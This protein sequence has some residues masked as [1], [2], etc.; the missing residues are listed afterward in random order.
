MSHPAQAEQ[1]IDYLN[2]EESKRNFKNVDGVVSMGYNPM[3]FEIDTWGSPSQDDSSVGRDPG[4][5]ELATISRASQLAGLDTVKVGRNHFHASKVI[6]HSLP[7]KGNRKIFSTLHLTNLCS[8]GL[9]THWL[10]L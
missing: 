10:V 8:N 9:K 4:A 6:H 1:Q 3:F 2:V 5:S 7:M